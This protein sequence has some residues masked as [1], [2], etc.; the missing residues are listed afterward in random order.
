M[1]QS[2]LQKATAKVDDWR[3]DAGLGKPFQN[4]LL[5]WDMLLN[6]LLNYIILTL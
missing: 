2:C 1:A 3:Q 6:D 4:R 5:E